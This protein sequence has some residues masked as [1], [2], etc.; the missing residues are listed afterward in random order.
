MNRLGSYSPRNSKK[1]LYGAI[2]LLVAVNV[3]IV[4]GCI[5]LK[6]YRFDSVVERD[7]TLYV[8]RE[9]TADSVFRQM[10]G[11][12][13]PAKINRLRRL[14]R[15]K[16]FPET[17]RT[18]A[19]LITPEMSLVDVY[20]LLTTGNPVPVLV[21]F[22][23]LRTVEDFAES[24]ARQLLP[25]K[26]EFLTLLNDTAFCR[27]KGFTLAT[28]PAM[29]LPDSYE[30]YW[31]T[32][33]ERLL[34]RM[35]REYGYY[36][37]DER[38]A[39]ARAMGFTPVEVATLAAIVE[40]ET[41]VAAEYPVVAGLYMNRL[42]R[43]IPLQADPTI[44]FALGDIRIKRILK[45]HL[46][47]DS[48]YNTYK[49]RGLPPGPIRIASKRAIEAVLNYTHHNYIYMCAK[50]DFSGRH[51]FAATLAEHNRNAAR[52]HRALN[53]HKIMK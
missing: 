13:A 20:D 23:N 49:Y 5:V 19:Y 43:G 17:L 45:K 40:E 18:G 1:R 14:T 33:A 39:K 41:N 50:E 22:N 28:V 25:E 52:Y 48:P 15:T 34:D 37:N 47:I 44:K 12:V 38:R 31:N 27:E 21:T 32:S 4:A 11:T 35:A 24:M 26:E 3:G 8:G 10:E 36:W 2:A 6:R 9:Y 46:Q 30:V 29:L 51:N 16:G 7:F 42:R 53:E